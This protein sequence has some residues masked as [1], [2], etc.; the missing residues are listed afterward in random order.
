MLARAAL[1]HHAGVAVL[2]ELAIDHVAAR[3]LALH[4]HRAHGV[5][6][7]VRPHDA[8]A[9]VEQVDPPPTRLRPV[10]I[11]ARALGA[12][13]PDRAE[14]VATLVL[15]HH[16]VGATRDHDAD[17]PP[18]AVLVVGAHLARVRAHERYRAA[19]DDVADHLVARPAGE[20][21]R[22]HVTVT[23]DEAVAA[24]ADHARGRDHHVA[25]RSAG[26]RDAIERG[27]VTHELH[28][29]RATRVDHD[30]AGRQ[31]GRGAH[32]DARGHDQREALADRGRVAART[33]V[34]DVTGGRTLEG[35]GDRGV[36]AAGPRR[37]ARR[38]LDHGHVFPIRDLHHV[39]GTERVPLDI[40]RHPPRAHPN[41][42]GTRAR[43]RRARTRAARRPAPR[44][45]APRPTSGRTRA[46]RPRHACTSARSRRARRTESSRGSR[47]RARAPTR[48]RRA[49]SAPGDPGTVPSALGPTFSSRLPPLATVS[50][51][52]AT[53][54]AAVRWSSTRSLRFTQ[55]EYASPR[56]SS[57]RP[58]G[59]TSG[60]SY[61]Y[62]V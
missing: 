44:S 56:H 3:G 54:C 40:A 30:P 1:D 29:D 60:T 7:L 32:R 62:T 26:N 5:P 17:A 22:L 6:R 31:I 43:S 21:D 13:D 47:R 51:S 4:V 52:R 59:A 8:L 42:T 15:A 49:V 61:S 46:P 12:R 34:D 55:K 11:D 9:R 45:A 28:R 19:R 48:P 2:G 24:R 27:A 16:V 36:A 23:H 35:G 14:V 39:P 41:Q 20:R 57:H 38:P 18:Q 53:T 58:A 10:V 37:A 50:T 33:D 25:G